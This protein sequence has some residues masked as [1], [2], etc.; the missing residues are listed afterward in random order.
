MLKKEL[1]WRRYEGP[2]FENNKSPN[3]GTL[4]WE[5]WDKCHLHVAPVERHKVYYKEGCDT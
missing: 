4:T 2:K 5:S 3:F 1:I